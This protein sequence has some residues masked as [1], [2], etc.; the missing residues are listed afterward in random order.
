MMLESVF[1]IVYF[2]S[3]RLGSIKTFIHYTESFLWENWGSKFSSYE[4]ELRNWVTQND[5]T[6]LVANLKIFV[7]IFSFELLT[8]LCKILN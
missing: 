1:H 3:K 4:V 2:K 5:A 8:E 6:L 7:E